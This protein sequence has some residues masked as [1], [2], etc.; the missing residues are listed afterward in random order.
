[1]ERKDVGNQNSAFRI[2]LNPY[3]GVKI[4]KGINVKLA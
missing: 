2:V 1:V 3:F 4:K